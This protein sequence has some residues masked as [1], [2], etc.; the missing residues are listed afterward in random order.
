MESN[1]SVSGGGY[2]EKVNQAFFI[3]GEG[4][5]S[6]LEDIRNIVVKNEGGVPIYIK[7]IAT[8]DFGS[9]IRFG[10]ITGRRKSFRSGNDAKRCEL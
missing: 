3:R 1:N 10:A 2:I 9:A 4:L 7:D 8:V 5:V 6:S